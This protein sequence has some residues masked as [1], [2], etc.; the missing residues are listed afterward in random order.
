VKHN[1]LEGDPRI[2]GEFEVGRV[3]NRRG[4]LHS[5]F[6]G[7]QQGGIATPQGQPFLLLFT[8]ES[9]EQYGYRDGWN[10][11]GVFVYTGEGQVGDMTFVRGNRAI[12]DHAADGK[13]LELFQNLGKGEGYRYLG[14]F[15]CSTWDYRRGRDREGNDRQVI[16]FHLLPIGDVAPEDLPVSEANG[17]DLDEL[18]KSAYTAA[19]SAVEASEGTAKRT[20]YARSAQVRAY[21]LRRANGVCESCRQPAPFD[22][23]DGT[24]Y[25]EP[26]HT[27]RVA[28]GGPDHPRWVGATCPNC[29]REIHFGTN[30][31]AKNTALQQ[32]LGTIEFPPR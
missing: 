6:G 30:G 7:Q 32:Y 5:R 15:L 3:Y 28:D 16:V 17:V 8:G 27:R 23:I 24:P 20:I 29:H 31:V 25:L 12:R 22:R 10:D 4:E 18:K 14:E 2:M 21:V 9:G 13:V 19:S 11:E 1:K 26:H